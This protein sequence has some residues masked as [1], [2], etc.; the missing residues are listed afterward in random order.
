MTSSIQSGPPSASFR[1]AGRTAL[2]TGGSG[3]LGAEA[4]RR[5]AAEGA[6]VVVHFHSNKT[7]AKAVVDSIT[8]KG[9]RAIALPGDLTDPIECETLVRAATDA[10][11]APGILVN[12]A[13]VSTMEAFGAITVEA[14]RR[15]FDAS[16]LSTILMTQAVVAGFGSDGGRIVNVASNLSYGPMAGL[17][18]YAAAKAAIVT[19][20]QGFA[21]E[22]AGRG[23]TVN[24]V[25]PGAVKTP[26][27]EWISGEIWEG[28]AQATPLRRTAEPDD[29]ADVIL[30]LASD[31]ARWV[32]GRTLIVDGGLV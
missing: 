27:T 2:I 13:G 10:L 1:F 20:T 30:F 26:M 23:I 21:R 22:L 17:T 15:D 8:A 4:A 19:L 9:G 28:I 14:Y 6:A 12:A 31:E 32:N 25:A 29:V 24:A 5:F 11:G 18:V 3:G 16:V 7:S